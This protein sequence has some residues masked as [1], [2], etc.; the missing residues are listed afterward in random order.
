MG[1]DAEFL[2]ATVNIAGWAGDKF[3]LPTYWSD[4]AG[5][6]VDMSSGSYTAYLRAS[7]TEG[8]VGTF[9]VDTTNAG[10]GTISL[11]IGTATTASLLS[12]SQTKWS[13]YWDLQRDQGSG[14]VRT[15][16]AGSA[17]FTLDTTR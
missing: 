7:R 10:D 3:I 6:L 5:T 2:P 13:G 11:S 17:T 9:T 14:V 15:L 8:T 1:V 16:L 12:W 4:S